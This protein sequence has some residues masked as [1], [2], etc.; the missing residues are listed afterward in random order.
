[1]PER[2]DLSPV[3]TL[4]MLRHAMIEREPG[5]ER[6]LRLTRFLMSPTYYGDNRR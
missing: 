6:P 3:N 2:G 5:R 1:M 4:F